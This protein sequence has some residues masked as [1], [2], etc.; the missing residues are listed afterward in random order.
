MKSL[1]P[2]VCIMY[3]AISSFRTHWSEIVLASNVAFG[4]VAHL[5]VSL[6]IEIG[7]KSLAGSVGMACI[8]YLVTWRK[9]ESDLKMTQQE[10]REE[11]KETDGNPQIKGRI[12]RLQRQIRRR[13]C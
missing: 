7:W 13:R 8:D 1:P 5:A 3:L 10:I 2:A 11:M 6:M 12:R 9:H 4:S